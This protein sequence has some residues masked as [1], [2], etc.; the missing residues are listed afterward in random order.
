[1]EDIVKLWPT[2]LLLSFVLTFVLHLWGKNKK[3][4][5]QPGMATKSESFSMKTIFF[6]F[7]NGE[8][9]LF[10]LVLTIT[11]LFFLFATGFAMEIG[12]FLPD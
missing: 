11:V 12:N 6:D 9:A 1:M 7:S 4:D 3:T 8:A 2:W 10:L 5:I